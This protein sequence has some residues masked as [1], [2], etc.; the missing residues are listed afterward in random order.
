M[1]QRALFATPHGGNR[2]LTDGSNKL[3]DLGALSFEEALKMLEENVTLMESGQLDLEKSLQAFEQGMMLSQHCTKLL[4]AAELRVTTM[5]MGALQREQALI[6][7]E[8]EE[9]L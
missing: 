3:D 7:D 5:A 4:N 2:E 1:R 8:D 9:D 6:G